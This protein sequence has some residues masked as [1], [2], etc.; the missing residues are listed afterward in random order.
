MYTHCDFNQF[1]SVRNNTF[2][3]ITAW[4]HFTAI[5]ISTSWLTL[6]FCF[7]S[8]FTLNFQGKYFTFKVYRHNNIIKLK[9]KTVRVSVNVQCRWTLFCFSPK[10][11]KEKKT[12][13]CASFHVGPS[14]V[15]NNTKWKQHWCGSHSVDYGRLCR[16]AQYCE[17]VCIWGVFV[18]FFCFMNCN[19]CHFLK[20]TIK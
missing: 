6:L 10:K 8:K 15:A 19:S 9:R 20:M 13:A 12:T 14:S 5:T 4:D 11:T 1:L 7:V 18:F 16:G 17:A 3:I 2:I